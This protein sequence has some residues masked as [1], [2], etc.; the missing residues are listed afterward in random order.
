VFTPARI[1]VLELLASQAATSLE[2]ARLH[3]DLQERETRIR[4]L[5]DSKIIGI[6]IW[7]FQV[8]FSKPTKSFSTCWATAVKSLS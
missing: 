3:N 1:S 4:R 2:I 8:G 7:N 6:V 5:V